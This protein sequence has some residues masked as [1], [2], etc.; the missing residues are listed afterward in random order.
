[1]ASNYGAADALTRYL[2][3]APDPSG[4]VVGGGG[5]DKLVGSLV[6]HGPAGAS[7][8]AAM[9]MSG[10]QRP[11]FVD[12]LASGLSSGLVE[13]FDGPDGDQWL[14]ATKTGASLY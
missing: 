10:L 11:M 7:L 6:P 13:Q 2:E 9:K 8:P 14:R 3:A 5:I 4:V 1:M 12:A